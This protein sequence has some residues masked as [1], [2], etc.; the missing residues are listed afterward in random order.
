MSAFVSLFN[1][2]LITI[3]RQKNK[4]RSSSR[5]RSGNFFRGLFFFLIYRNA[6]VWICY[7][8]WILSKIK[9]FSW[10][11]VKSEYYLK[12][13]DKKN[14]AFYKSLKASNQIH[15]IIL[16]WCYSFYYHKYDEVS[17]PKLFL[18]RKEAVSRSI[19]VLL[20]NCLQVFSERPVPP[21]P[22]PF[23]LFLSFWQM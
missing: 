11:R 19:D 4:R 10:N 16:Y 22:L 15:K 13:N 9:T 1:R 20:Y 21:F 3:T 2:F 7:W 18:S 23:S 5:Q 6:Y 8:I 14:P 17:T 12:Q